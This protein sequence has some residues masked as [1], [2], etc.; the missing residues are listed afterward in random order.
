M[1]P[2]TSQHK[3]DFDSI[4]DRR[5][6]R[7]YYATLA[8]LDYQIP[9]HGCDVTARLLDRLRE[10]RPELTVLD[11]CC[12]YGV[13][14]MLLKTDLDLGKL[15]EHYADPDKAELNADGIADADRQVLDEHRHPRAPRV[16]GLDVASRAIGYAV[17]TGALDDG[18]AENLETDEPTDHL[19]EML[20]EVDLVTTTGGVGYVTEKTYE[21]LVELTPD[22]TWFAT[23]CLR[24]YDFSPIAET[25]A[26]SGRR[27]ETATRTFRQRRF[28]D[29]DEQKWAV[30]EATS[31]GFDPAGK[32]DD[33]YF[34]AE[35]HLSRPVA[36]ADRVPFGDLLPDL[37]VPES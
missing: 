5:D 16:V 13:L 28:T 22:S 8:P 26:R 29:P 7:G 11:V 19:V 32:E 36:D 17:G 12:S 20:G 34:H 23:F 1:S 14:A 10:T 33:G 37:L 24:T 2:E 21:R 35:L 31:W 18:A 9:Q 4:Y 27:T 25:M 30:A 3:A 6:P 15:C